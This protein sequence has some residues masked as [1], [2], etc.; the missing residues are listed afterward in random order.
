MVS[1]MKK[2]NNI[3]LLIFLFCTFYSCKED[4]FGDTEE[5][6]DLINNKKKFFIVNSDSIIIDRSANPTEMRIKYDTIIPQIT[7][8]EDFVVISFD[9][10]K[11]NLQRVEADNLVSRRI[12]FSEMKFIKGD[13]VK[14]KFEN[15][16]KIPSEDCF[17]TLEK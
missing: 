5:I 11:F 7:D 8:E 6:I 10:N 3:W 4:Y 12:Y 17:I 14:V 15:C 16:N 1:C 2:L 9:K 13:T